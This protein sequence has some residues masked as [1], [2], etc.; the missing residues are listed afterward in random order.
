VGGVTITPDQAAS[1]GVNVKGMYESEDTK[2]V[3]TLM[4]NR[5]GKT[6]SGDYS[7]SDEVFY[8]DDVAFTKQNFPNLVG[9]TNKDV[10]AN[11]VTSND[12]LHYGVFYIKS[13]DGKIVPK[14]VGPYKDLDQLVQM[15]KQTTPQIIDLIP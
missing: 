3:R 10:K 2:R 8:N 4:Q 13:R 7:N 1:L 11:I 9:Y 12:G 5:G 14:E 6:S 15:M